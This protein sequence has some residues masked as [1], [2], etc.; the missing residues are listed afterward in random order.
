M[1]L[2]NLIAEGHKVLCRKDE[3]INH[4]DF[5]IDNLKQEKL[6][7]ETRLNEPVLELQSR[8]SE[9]AENYQN[10]IKKLSAIK[11]DTMKALASSK[12]SHSTLMS[13]MRYTFIIIL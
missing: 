12:E 4:Q 10:E 2:E 13:E 9:E 1:H 6:D 7:L 3:Y 8:R 5:I 11:A